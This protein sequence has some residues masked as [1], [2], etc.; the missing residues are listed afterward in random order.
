MGRSR[1]FSFVPGRTRRSVPGT[2]TSLGQSAT[3]RSN[4]AG[5]TDAADR[6]GRA[7]RTQRTRRPP[8]S[9]PAGGEALQ[10]LGNGPCLGARV[11]VRDK[12]R[13]ALR[14]FRWQR[15]LAQVPAADRELEEPLQ[16]EILEVPRCGNGAGASQ[17]LSHSFEPD[18]SEW[19]VRCRL[20]SRTPGSSP[21]THRPQ[22]TRPCNSE[23]RRNRD[24]RLGSRRQ[25]NNPVP[26]RPSL[27]LS[28]VFAGCA[29]IGHQLSG[30]KVRLLTCIRETMYVCP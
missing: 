17:E 3:G 23:Q 9:P 18:P 8:T 26:V 1:L 2:S 22:R 6:P 28:F 20:P 11:N 19:C 16:R 21:R 14:H 29:Q 13:W 4:R 25:R 7:D 10:I 27:F 12:C 24:T 5:A 30:A 15:D